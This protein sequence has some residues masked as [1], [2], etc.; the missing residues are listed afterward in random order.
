MQTRGHA[1]LTGLLPSEYKLYPPEIAAT[2]SGYGKA[3]TSTWDG[4]KH[5]ALNTSKVNC[6]AVW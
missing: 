4:T 3:W 6:V 1:K 2:M 5:W